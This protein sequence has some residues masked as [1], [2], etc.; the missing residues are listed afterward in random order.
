MEWGYA[1]EP[2]E[3]AENM[4]RVLR[5]S[6]VGINLEDSIREGRRPIPMEFRCARIRAVREMAL[7]EGVPLVNARTDVFWPRVP[8]T[9]AEKFEEAVPPCTGL[10]RGRC[11]LLLSY[12]PG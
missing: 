12:H 6:A 7:Q 5:A 4:R 10:L 9:E 8:G 11:R 3:V 1:E 2:Q